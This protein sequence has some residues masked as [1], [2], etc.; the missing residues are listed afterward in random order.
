MALVKDVINSTVFMPFVSIYSFDRM[1]KHD[2]NSVDYLLLEWIVAIE[3]IHSVNIDGLRVRK[4]YPI[5]F[6]KIYEENMR[7]N[8][9]S[10]EKFIYV[11]IEKIPEIVPT[12]TLKKA[13]EML[14]KYDIEITPVFNNK[15]TVKDIVVRIAKYIGKEFEGK[16]DKKIVVKTIYEINL[17]AKNNENDKIKEKLKVENNIN[18]KQMNC[19]NYK[20]HDIGLLII[21]YFIYILYG[22][23]VNFFILYIIYIYI[24]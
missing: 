1:M 22:V 15:S 16:I 4:I 18:N 7:K 12:L 13:H 20:S 9:F 21:I 23:S 11:L 10:V 19:I 24:F 6:G 8:V 2:E 3:C 14:L 17:L 5:F